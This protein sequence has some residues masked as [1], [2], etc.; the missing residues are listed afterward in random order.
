MSNND[1]NDAATDANLSNKKLNDGYDGAA[2]DKEGYKIW[3]GK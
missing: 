2:V 3:S 1:K